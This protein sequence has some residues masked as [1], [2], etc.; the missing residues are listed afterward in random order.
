MGSSATQP[1]SVPLR[2]TKVPPTG[3]KALRDQQE[4]PNSRNSTLIRHRYDPNF[5][6]TSS[7]LNAPAPGV[8]NTTSPVVKTPKPSRPTSSLSA[9]T[10]STN[11]HPIPAPL[12]Q[13]H[14]PRA[15]SYP[16]VTKQHSSALASRYNQQVMRDDISVGGGYDAS[17]GYADQPSLSTL[18]TSGF[19]SLP[20]PHGQ[21]SNQY[22]HG[23]W[24][25]Y[26]NNPRIPPQ[27][28]FS[29]YWYEQGSRA[30][31]GGPGMPGIG[32]FTTPSTLPHQGGEN[33]RQIPA[34]S[35]ADLGLP[36]PSDPSTTMEPT[37]MCPIAQN[38]LPI[39]VEMSQ[40][41]QPQLSATCDRHTLAPF[42]PITTQSQ[43]PNHQSPVPPPLQHSVLKMELP[44]VQ[45]RDPF[46]APANVA[47]EENPSQGY[48]Q[49]E[50]VEPFDTLPTPITPSVLQ[51]PNPRPSSPPKG[52]I[53]PTFA[54]ILSPLPEP[55]TRNVFSRMQEVAYD[56]PD[57]AAVLSEAES[58]GRP[59]IVRNFPL[60]TWWEN[61][62]LNPRNLQRILEKPSQPCIGAISLLQI[63]YSTLIA[64]RFIDPKNG[65]TPQCFH[66]NAVTQSL[67]QAACL[68][69]YL[70]VDS[71]VNAP[72]Q[73][74]ASANF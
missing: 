9:T 34:G 55:Y 14:N 26:R 4:A 13:A 38:S 18:R 23:S 39:G 5:A 46:D 33:L 27:G 31:Q 58:D 10:P 70:P 61:T 19:T 24:E 40:E 3:P 69:S 57:L 28:A 17:N 15:K 44:P 6:P 73:V 65:D 49:A 30:S 64:E 32:T 1:A 35:R 56:S 47:R 59:V 71:K 42:P 20:N 63:P 8:V 50:S 2:H 41:V 72:F 66:L 74:F 68:S 21:W 29:E 62:P 16:A 60:C 45:T 36:Y 12:Q 22:A 11:S 54:D 7:Q 37:T 51:L 52:P 67:P 53:L 48:V 43:H 25:S